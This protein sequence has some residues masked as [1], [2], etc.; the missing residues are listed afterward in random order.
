MLRDYLTN[1]WVLGAIG[2]LILLSVTCVFWY[3]HDTAPYKHE[4]AKA[5]ELLREHEAA[6]ISET[7]TETKLLTNQTSSDYEISTKGESIRD[8]T[9]ASLKPITNTDEDSINTELKSQIGEKVSPYGF[10]PYPDVPQGFID[11]IGAPFWLLP[12][13]ILIQRSSPPTSDV[14]LIFRVMVRLWTQG[15]TD[16]EA[17]FM[18]GNKVIVHYKNRVYVRYNRYK[19]SKGE[20]VRYISSWRSGSVPPP[21]PNP[22]G[23]LDLTEKDVPFG[24]ELIDM[25]KEDH[26]IDPYEFLGLN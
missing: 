11:A 4:L 16:V 20:E 5:E 15:H 9:D 23:E 19:N 1:K 12:D 24:V 22:N 8:A 17:G 3:R 2:F 26:G 14:E 13:E 10:G 25:D 21:E 18:D 6:H 7:S